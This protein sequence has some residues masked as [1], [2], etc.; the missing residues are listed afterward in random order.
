MRQIKRDGRYI[1]TPFLLQ[2][3]QMNGTIYCFWSKEHL[4]AHKTNKYQKKM[5]IECLEKKES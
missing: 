1:F 2:A 5:S 3:S 4:L